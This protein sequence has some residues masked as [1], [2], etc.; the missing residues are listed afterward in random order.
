M[1]RGTGEAFKIPRGIAV[2]GD[3]AEDGDGNLVVVD[4]GL[5]AVVQVDPVT[6][7]RT[8]ISDNEM[9]DMEPYFEDPRGIAVEGDIAEDG[10]IW[11][12]DSDAVIQ[13]NPNDTGERTIISMIIS[14]SG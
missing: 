14:R 3:I 13:V 12:L 6:G 1:G 9:M 4:S 10:Y 8:T 11:V 7:D 2:E 5:K